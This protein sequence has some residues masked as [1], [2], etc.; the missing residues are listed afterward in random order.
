MKK[1]IKQAVKFF[2]LSGCGWLLDF[3]A[4][5]ALGLWFPQT[6]FWNNI[7]SSLVGATFVYL[8]S[9]RMVFQQSGKISL[10][11]KYLIYLT[12]QIVLIVSISKLL[13]TI[14]TLIVEHMTWEIILRSSALLSKIIV[15]P[16]TMTLNFFVMKGVIEKL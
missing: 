3:T 9:T 5:T 11:W 6:L 8:F 7:I 16:V 10:K 12:Y 1:L 15:T 2:G 4:Y 13:A 14:N